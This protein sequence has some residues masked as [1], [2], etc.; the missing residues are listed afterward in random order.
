MTF[1]ATAELDAP[2]TKPRSTK[3]PRRL[4]LLT[5]FLAEQQQLTAVEAF[6]ELHDAGA[7]PAQAR[8]YEN[9]LPVSKPGAGEQFAFGVDLDRCTSCKACVTACHSLN[10]LDAEETWRWVGALH[11]GDSTSPLQQTVTAAC[12]HCLEPAC[13]QGCPVNAYEKDPI[14]GIVRHLDDQCIGCQYCTLTCPYEVPQFN[15]R[16]GIVRKCDMCSDRLATGEAPACV[17]ACPNEAIAI[18]IVNVAELR[19]NSSVQAALPHAPSPTLTLPTTE[20]KTQRERPE[21]TQ[22]ADLANLKP[23]ARHTPLVF[24]L[25]L[26]Q[27]SVGLFT[28]EWL[29]GGFAAIPH[30]WL[31]ALA[32]GAAVLGLGLSTSHLGRPLYGFRALVGIGHSW[33]SREIAC[34]GLFAAVASCYAALPWLPGLAEDAT[35]H[36]LLGAAV[37]VSGWASVACSILLYVVTRRAW[38]RSSLTISKFVGS[39]ILL[40]LAALQWAL[41]VFSPQLPD[42]A[43]LGGVWL[44]LALAGGTKLAHEGA[45]LVH[46]RGP[47]LGE[48]DKSAQLML[49]P[50]RGVTRTRFVLG[51]IAVFGLPALLAALQASGASAG[52]LAVLASSLLLLALCGELLERVA[53]FAAC[54]PPKMPGGIGA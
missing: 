44:L 34:F 30:E 15:P 3:E 47:T 32:L 31:R 9:L 13:L 1:A 40:G 4:P 26:T 22:P 16:L 5:Q 24:M 42:A 18:R 36:R 2:E 17:Q 10:G 28:F 39:S 19:A 41:V 51:L 8:Y 25:V 14:T 46:A 20:Y 43:L 6:S 7:L 29:L 53:F 45:Q 11:G 52:T 37:V 38:W 48:L 21:N 54:A 50:L 27:L 12:H 33:M 23:A 35:L 49:G